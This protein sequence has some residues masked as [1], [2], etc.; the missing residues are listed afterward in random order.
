[1]RFNCSISRMTR[2]IWR[3]HFLIG[4]LT[5]HSSASEEILIDINDFDFVIDV[6]ERD[7]VVRPIQLVVI[8][9]ALVVS[10]DELAGTGQRVVFHRIGLVDH[11]LD[12]DADVVSLDLEIR[13]KALRGFGYLGPDFG[14]AGC[15]VGH[16]R[17][18][19]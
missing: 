19:G 1:M 5:R 14:L 2:S 15:V 11:L 16:T 13:G 7:G 18:A 17:I 9:R 6:I 4:R 12:H 3:V 8:N 10:M